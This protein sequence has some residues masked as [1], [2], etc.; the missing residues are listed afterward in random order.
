M[1][2]QFP[3][4]TKAKIANVN[5]R[6][7]KHG[8]DNLVPAVDITVV[9]DQ[10]NSILD[11]FHPDLLGLIYC[12]REGGVD[13]G[14]TSL[15]GVDEVSDV[16]NLRFPFMGLP[17]VWSKELSGYTFTLDHGLGGKSELILTDCKVNNFRIEPKEG[18]TVEVKF[19]VQSSTSLTE[20]TLG[21]L[22]LLIQHEVPFKLVPP[23]AEAQQT[24]ENPFIE[25]ELTPEAA[26]TQGHDAE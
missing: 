3:N 24:M 26:F 7:E 9:M 1:T 16:P 23:K 19:R 20:K 6:S 22:A 10:P 13:E 21:K 15:D 14:Q 5:A 12:K 18:G 17:L 2:F 11:A 8:P 25:P 4:F